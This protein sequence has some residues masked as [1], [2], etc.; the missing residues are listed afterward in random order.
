MKSQICKAFCA[1]LSV[2]EFHNGFAIGTPYGNLSGE[3]L[4]F[5]AVGP[6][7]DGFYRIMDDGTTI[8]VIEASGASL[9]S[10]TRYAAFREILS[11]YN[12]SYSELERHISIEH[13]AKDDIAS[14]SIQFIALLLRLQDLLLMTR[15]R[16]EG[17]FR[18]DVLEKLR[19]RFAGR[20]SIREN[21]PVSHE[22][23]AVTPD[24]VLQA[25]EKEPV[26]IFVGTTVQKISDAV[27]LHLLATYTQKIP[28]RVV[29]VLEEDSSLPRKTEQRASNFLDAVPRYSGD[30]KESIDRIE[31]EVFGRAAIMHSIH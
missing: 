7:D 16:I 12:A 9:D 4:G 19:E 15:E 27:I 22:L 18:D 29:A 14:Q 1:E 26:A 20:A 5:Y 24:M 30:G 17:S 3:P 13:V 11:E 8:P 10:E 21:E 31:R 6:D 23:A 2:R 25:S 28:L